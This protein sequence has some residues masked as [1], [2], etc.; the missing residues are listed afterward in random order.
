MFPSVGLGDVFVEVEEEE[1]TEGLVWNE[2]EEVTSG[3]PCCSGVGEERT[4]GWNVVLPEASGHERGREMVCIAVS[5]P[6][7]CGKEWG[8]GCFR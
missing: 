7:L 8:K 6:L 5:F 4:S 1:V 3:P 2:L